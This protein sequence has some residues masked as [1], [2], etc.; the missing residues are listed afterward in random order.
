MRGR[1]GGHHTLELTLAEI[2]AALGEP[3]GEPVAHEGGR[4]RAARR[5]P[6]PAADDAAA[7]RGD[8]VLGELLPGQQH[9]AEADGGMRAGEFQ[10]ALHRGKDLADAEKADHG[11]EEIE[12]DQQLLLP[13]GH[14]KRAGHLV[15]ADR[16]QRE[17]EAHGGQ[18]LEG[19]ASAH[20]YKA[21]ER[22]KVD[23]EEL[24]R[25]ELQR[26]LGDQRRQEGDQDHGHQGA[27]EGGRE[28]CGERL[29]GSTLLGKWMP[30]EGSRHRPG[31]A[32]D[33]EENGGDRPAE[34]RSPVDA[35]EHDDGRGRRHREGE[36]QQNCHPVGP[37]EAR[38]NTDDDAEQDA[39][40]HQ[41]QVIPG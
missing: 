13:E 21:G 6:H 5:Y 41:G 31:L 7:D 30:I 25:T 27:D 14:P 9:R 3:L 10:A 11:H 18:H 29:I 8:P 1:L 22:K 2:I 17:A 4:R 35:G 38:Q 33:I 39:D 36:G 15:Q 12:A 32:R 24:R 37:A 28:G 23:R 16:T 19:R 34:Q 26:E 20:S 40:H